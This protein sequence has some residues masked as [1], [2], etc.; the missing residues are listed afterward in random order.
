MPSPLI[1]LNSKLEDIMTG[2]THV[3]HI[4]WQVDR[5]YHELNER[6]V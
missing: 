6:E 3:E 4:G 2:L 5:L 1:E